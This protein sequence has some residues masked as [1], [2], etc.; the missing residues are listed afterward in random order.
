MC[1]GQGAKFFPTRLAEPAVVRVIRRTLRALN[2]HIY[3]GIKR[4][5]TIICNL[6]RNAKKVWSDETGPDFSILGFLVLDK[7]RIRERETVRNSQVAMWE[8]TL[9]GP[10]SH[11]TWPERKLSSEYHNVV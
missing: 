8:V 9:T 4:T 10:I 5:E 1:L 7:H 6:V 2:H 11:K 3:L